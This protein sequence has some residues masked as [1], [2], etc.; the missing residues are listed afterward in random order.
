MYS[1]I[2]ASLPDFPVR[3]VR[4][5]L[6]WTAVV[7]EKDSGLQCGLASTLSAEH[8]HTGEPIIP[9]P[10]KL[11]SYPALQLASWIESE[12]PL[13]RS[14][15]C[16]AINALL[17]RQP[18]SWID[19]NAE[20]AILTRSKGGKVVVI[21]HFPFSKTLQE[22][23]ADFHVLELN[24]IADDRPASLAPDLLPK[25]DLVAITG[26]AFI[27]HTLPELLFLCKPGAYVLLL[28][29][30]TPLTPILADFGVDL[31]AGS[32]VEDIPAVLAAVSQGANFRQ[33][34]HAGV[35]LITQP[36]SR[37]AG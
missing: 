12:I 26:M 32:S 36:T 37:S 6:H 3:Q 2:L 28:G 29:P 5:G 18:Q 27:N 8:H 34:H 17:P 31:L 11:E 13:R 20:Q 23:I 4:I 25:A 9:D 16:A 35:R 24:P 33:V 30:S 14:L 15:G 19:Q 22:S 7:V 1:R 10:G 21:G